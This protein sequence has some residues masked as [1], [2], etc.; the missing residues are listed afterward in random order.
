MY[1]LSGSLTSEVNVT[2]FDYLV[3]AVGS[4]HVFAVLSPSLGLFSRPPSIYQFSRALKA[5]TL[6]QCTQGHMYKGCGFQIS[7]F[8]FFIDQDRI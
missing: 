4:D 8:N 3:D 7:E 1:L 6:Y 2:S 5:S